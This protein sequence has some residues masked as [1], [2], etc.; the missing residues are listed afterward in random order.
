MKKL[1]F[2]VLL[3]FVLVLNGCLSSDEEP[4]DPNAQLEA[5]IMAIDEYLASNNIDAEAHETGFRYIIE[6][7]GDGPAILDSFPIIM[8]YEAQT[9]DGNVFDEDD[10]FYHTL[11][12]GSL[13]AWEVGLPFINEGG[14]IIMYI[15]SGLGFGAVPLPELPANSNTIYRITVRNSDIQLSDD[16]IEINR[17][18]AENNIMAEE[19]ESGLRYVIH[20]LGDPDQQP[21]SR[22]LVRVNY[23]GRLLSDEVFDEG[24]LQQFNL[25]GVIMG[26]RVGV[27]LIGEGGSITL[28]IP[29]KLAFGPEVRGIIRGNAPLIFDIELVAVQ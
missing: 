27:P 22:G 19:H 14:T 13:P 11:N 4:F 20:D 8:S 12:A 21:D 15:P 26:W 2:P 1:L 7:M 28:Y 17:Y 24:Q 18:L 10:E 9:L 25:T 5:D 3:S 6:E 23:E 29:S 16:L